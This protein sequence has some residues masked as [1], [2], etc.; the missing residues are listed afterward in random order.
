MHHGDICGCTILFMIRDYQLKLNPIHN[1]V[2]INRN[3]LTFT[4]YAFLNVTAEVMV[5]VCRTLP[6]VKFL[7]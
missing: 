3:V 7:F 2:E 1:N 6:V 4:Q 5:R